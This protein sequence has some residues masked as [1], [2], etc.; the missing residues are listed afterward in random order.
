[1]SLAINTRV[2]EI[3]LKLR[4]DQRAIIQNVTLKIKLPVILPAKMGSLGKAR[5]ETC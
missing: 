2:L 4:K 3:L 1:M 5:K